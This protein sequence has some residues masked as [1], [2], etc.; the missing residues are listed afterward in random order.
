VTGGPER[1]PND[2][3]ITDDVGLTREVYE[4]KLNLCPSYIVGYLIIQ[5]IELMPF[6]RSQFRIL[7]RSEN[8]AG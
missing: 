5:L 4:D 8:R 2:P 1:N 7:C 3:I 6:S